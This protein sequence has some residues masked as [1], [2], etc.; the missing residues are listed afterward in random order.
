MKPWKYC[1][2]QKLVKWFYECFLVHL[3]YRVDY[4]IVAILEWQYC[5]NSIIWLPTNNHII[6]SQTAPLW[7]NLMDITIP[8]STLHIKWLIMKAYFS[9]SHYFHDFIGGCD[10][11]RGIPSMHT[12]MQSHTCNFMRILNYIFYIHT[13]P[14]PEKYSDHWFGPFLDF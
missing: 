1:H 10:V 2:L 8:N 7:I 5:Q 14:P 4:G 13:S 12:C 9:M 3:R 6:Q 11:F